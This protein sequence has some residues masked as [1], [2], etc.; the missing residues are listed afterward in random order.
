M[1]VSDLGLQQI[2]LQSFQQAQDAA[3]ARQIALSSG[4]KFQTYGGYGADALRLVSA[5]GV[6]A[7]ATSF[8]R[9]SDI[10]LTRL[11]LQEANISI[12]NDA[13]ASLRDGFRRTLASGA[14]E[15]L[16]PEVAAEAQG[17]LSALNAQ[18]GGVYLFGGDDG[19]VPPIDARS[20][21]DIGDVGAIDD[22]F[23]EGARVRLAVEEGVLI[24]GGPLA[25]EIAR[26][27]LG[28]L[29]ELANAPTTF[30][31]FQGELTDAQR[32]FIVE[33]AERFVAIGDD[34]IE[35]LGVNGV[36]QGQAADAVER[37]RQRR[38]LAEIVAAEIE[39]VDIAEAMAR[40]NQDQLALEASARA[41][42]EASR[43]SLLNFI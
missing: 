32:A 28:Q 37:N 22:L 9:A 41:L 11:Q 40:L 33:K 8:E 30:G 23:T 15:R 1:R 42:A 13:V 36:A 39:D 27:L 35:T 20:L 25:S 3:N 12:I 5:E 6:V 18:F 43:L 4:K 31:P 14:S 26:D 24:D 16:P 17:I 7:R 10:A 29:Q 34:L 21:G 2:L 38:D 19:T